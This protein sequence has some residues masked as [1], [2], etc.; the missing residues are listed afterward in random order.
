MNQKLY[1]CFKTELGQAN[2]SINIGDFQRCWYH[3]E[4]AHILGQPYPIPH[5]V[6]HWKMLCFGFKVKNYREVVGQLPRL[7]FGGI[8][9]LVGTVPIGN[10]GGANVPALKPMDIPPDLKLIIGQN[11]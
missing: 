6:V 1:Q 8:K 10:T 7:I 2:T 3:L 9:S 4:R 11:R 5:S